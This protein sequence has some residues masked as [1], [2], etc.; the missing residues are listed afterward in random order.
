MIEY[1]KGVNVMA[2]DFKTLFGGR[3][4]PKGVKTV[5]KG[6][7]YDCIEGVRMILDEMSKKH[8]LDIMDIALDTLRIKGEENVKDVSSSYIMVTSDTGEIFGKELTDIQ[9][10]VLMCG[11][12]LD[13][14]LN[15][16]S[17]DKILALTEM[18]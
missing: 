11:L 12:G 14:K 18:G 7:A 2:D 3:I 15:C 8:K 5:V 4:T 13:E 1:Q 10:Y 6:D 17:D 16:M 9:T